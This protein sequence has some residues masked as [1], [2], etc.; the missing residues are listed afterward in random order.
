MV[1]ALAGLWIEWSGVEPWPGS[2]HC[3]Q[4]TTLILSA[5]LHLDVENMDTGKFTAGDDNVMD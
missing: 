1:S 3:V 4:D 2:L 5:S